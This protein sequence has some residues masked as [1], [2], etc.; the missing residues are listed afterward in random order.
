MTPFTGACFKPRGGGLDPHKLTESLFER[1]V[2]AGVNIA[3]RC[4]VLGIT[5]EGGHFDI[6]TELGGIRAATVVLATNAYTGRPIPGL[7]RR[8]V[9]VGG[10]AVVTE[11]LG[12]DLMRQLMPRGRMAHDSRWRALF[13]A[14][15]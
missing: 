1:A 10:H 8:Q 5:D 2:K 13:P 15:P 6:Q 12:Q 11:P 7:R 14:N 9:R 4:G 3:S